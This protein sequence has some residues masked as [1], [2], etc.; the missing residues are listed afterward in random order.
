MDGVTAGGLWIDFQ[1]YALKGVR[2]EKHRATPID[3]GLPTAPETWVD[4]RDFV[5]NGARPVKKKKVIAPPPQAT[6]APTP[7]PVR[8]PP[9]PEHFQTVFQAVEEL[10]TVLDPRGPLYQELDQ[11]L[12]TARQKHQDGILPEAEV[13]RFSRALAQIREDYAR[14]SEQIVDW[15]LDN[16]FRMFH[17]APHDPP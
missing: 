14:G 7:A 16:Y 6:P 8:E 5:V 2:K 4:I 9:P 3:F 17:T 1:D 11:M 10:Y 12:A 13:E 15:Y